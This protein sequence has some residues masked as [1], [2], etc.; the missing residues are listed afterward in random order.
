MK[1]TITREEAW[2]LLNKYIKKSEMLYHARESEE[3]ARLLAEKLGE[4]VEL[5]GNTAMLHDL[6]FEEIGEDYARH[7]VRTIEILRSEGYEIPEMFQAILAHTEAM[8]ESNTKRE[9]KMDYAIAA[10]ETISGF[11]VAVALMRPNKFD[12][13]EVKSI[14]KKLKDKAFAAK[15]NR[16]IIS[17]IEKT[18][19]SQ[20]EFIEIA[21]KAVS[22][23]KQEIGF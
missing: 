1:N 14:K 5:W 2:E 12:D 11:I 10:S 17:D 9:S 4:N 21:I 7:G 13:L 19:L 22:G 8:E 6:D 3:I 20:D 18:G 23:I 16:E 15:V